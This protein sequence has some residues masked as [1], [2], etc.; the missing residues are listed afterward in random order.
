MSRKWEKYKFAWEKAYIYNPL[1]W[2]SIDC[3]SHTEKQDLQ[4]AENW[5]QNSKIYS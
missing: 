2:A 5:W 4:A 1:L 3:E